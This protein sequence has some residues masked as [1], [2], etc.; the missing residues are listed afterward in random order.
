MCHHLAATESKQSS[1][2]LRPHSTA[3]V[4]ATA[5]NLP[6]MG[7]PTPTPTSA[8]RPNSLANAASI[9]LT[10]SAPPLIATVLISGTDS[11]PAN[12]PHQ[13]SSGFKV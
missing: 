7:F 9:F 11:A 4:F 10:R 12:T 1:V 8:V 3:G 2:P 13:S 5:S 6:L